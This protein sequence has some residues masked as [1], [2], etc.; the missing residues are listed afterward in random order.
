MKKPFALDFNIYYDTD[1]CQAVK[2][3]LDH[4]DETPNGTDL[5]LMA[6]YIMYGKSRQDD[7]NSVEK[8]LITDDFTKK[9]PSPNKAANRVQ[10]LEYL[11]EEQGLPEELIQSLDKKSIYY[12]KKRSIDRKDPEIA[13]IPGMRDLWQSI[14]AL[15]EQLDLYQGKIEPLKGQIVPTYETGIAYKKK[16]LLR[17]MQHQ[18]YE[19][20]DIFKPPIIFTKLHNPD[21]Q[22][23]DFTQDSGYWTTQQNARKKLQQSYFPPLKVNRDIDKMPRNQKGEV[24]WTL[25]RQK[26][27]FGN[28]KHIFQIMRHYTKLYE[29]LYDKPDSW[30]RAMLW[31]F[32]ALF[33][34]TP[35]RDDWR[36]IFIRRIDG[37]P[38]DKIGALIQQETGHV[39]SQAAVSQ[40]WTQRIPRALARQ[41]Q[42]ETDYLT[43]QGYFKKCNWCGEWYPAKRPFFSTNMGHRYNLSNKCVWC[44]QKQYYDKKGETE[45]DYRT[46][47]Y[48]PKMP[49]RTT[50]NKLPEYPTK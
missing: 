3:I 20:L 41:Y 35:M 45:N 1:R 33:D 26:I 2:S 25:R 11:L 38:Y 37:V 24:W 23:V 9:R 21:M 49:T 27:D 4:L 46:K 30:G 14:D 42:W 29:D 19:L 16:C 40:I 5:Q 48:L 18:Q 7:K 12:K 34:R 43:W 44:Q 17:D 10:S 31:D 6:S 50:F 13:A 36:N 28:A 32:Q 22:T 8:G 39:Y 15:K 47:S